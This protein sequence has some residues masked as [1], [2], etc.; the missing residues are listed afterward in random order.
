M[1]ITRYLRQAKDSFREN[2]VL[3]IFSA[4]FYAVMIWLAGYLNIWE[5]ELYTLNTTSGTLSYALNQSFSFE[6]QPPVYFLL[7]TVWRLGSSSILW[8]RMMNILLIFCAQI[9]LFRFI[10]TATDR[11]VAILASIL[12]LLNPAVIFTILEIRLY[13]LVILLSLLI[14]VG[15]L[16]T[17]YN[18]PSGYSN[19]IVFIILAIIGVYTQYYIGFLLLANSVVLLLSRRTRSFRIYVL[20][21][22]VPLAAVALIVPLILGNIRAQTGIALTYER[23]FT[24]YLTEIKNI[25]SQVTF[26]Y[27]MPSDFIS[28]AFFR[29]II[30]L[31]VLMLFFLTIDFKR[32]KTKLPDSFLLLTVTLFTTL[33]FMVVDYKFGRY[34]T[35]SKYTLVI[36][37]PLYLLLIRAFIHLKPGY[38]TTWI[39]FFSLFYLGI[40]FDN[41]HNLYKHNDFRR[42][43]SYLERVEKQ[44]E[45][46]LVYRNVMADNLKLYYNGINHICP[47]PHPFVY[48]SGIDP[49]LWKIQTEDLVQLAENLKPVERF[50][51]IIVNNVITGFEESKQV[52]Y[53]FLVKNYTLESEKH[54]EKNIYLYTFF[55]SLKK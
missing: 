49:N 33:I 22:I 18:G 11:K 6:Q 16:K 23:S 51:V 2:S 42:L 35:E 31:V 24:G 39:I 53:D 19:R 20:D 26:G 34:S 1:Q 8:A 47:L 44:N 45:P 30:R 48:N 41:Y 52:L 28:P 46:V 32:V 40:G 12:F 14:L 29:W 37:L 50:Q 55:N 54:F 13:A 36:F 25:I 7:L 10:R 9:I 15:F 3:V 27:F 21:M 4:V 38:M 43:G 17:Y 5:D